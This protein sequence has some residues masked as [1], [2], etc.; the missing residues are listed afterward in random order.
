MDRSRQEMTTARSLPGSLEQ[1]RVV[2]LGQIAAIVERTAA[3]ETSGEPRRIAYELQRRGWLGRLRTMNA[4]EFFP[5]VRA[6]AYGSGDRFIELRAQL[7]IRRSR[8]LPLGLSC[9]SGRAVSPE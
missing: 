8:S 3:G 2:T 4:W 5:G 6:G 7:A 9:R 1:P